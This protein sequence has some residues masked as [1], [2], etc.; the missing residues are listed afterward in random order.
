M[1]LGIGST[2]DDVKALQIALDARGLYGGEIDGVFGPRTEAAVRAL[3]EH[4]GLVVDGIVGPKTWTVLLAVRAPWPEPRCWPLKCLPDGR[5]PHITSG[6]KARN[7]ERSNH[8]GVDIMYPYKPGDPPMKIGDGGRTKTWW[9][10]EN[11]Y[12]IAPFAGE[13]VLAS[14]S[15]TGKRAWLRHPSG[16]NAGFFHMDEFAVAVGWQVN[17]GAVIGRVAD[18]PR[19]DDPDHE[20]F[21]LY[22]GNIVDDVKH[23]LYPRGTVDPQLMLELT[24]FLPA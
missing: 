20:H 16:W 24:P 11:T 14:D 23:G 21:E 1:I 4:E 6:H 9:I 8:Y 2:G 22:W 13:I 12:A 10:P 17:M 7:P 3:Q 18:S 19:G 5:K 15:P